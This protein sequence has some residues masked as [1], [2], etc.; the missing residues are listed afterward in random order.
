MLSPDVYRER[1]LS[2]EYQCVSTMI[3]MPN[4]DVLDFLEDTPFFIID[5]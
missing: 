5:N 1:I 4:L 2:T 3:N